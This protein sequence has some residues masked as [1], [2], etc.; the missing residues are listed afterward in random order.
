MDYRLNISKKGVNA[1]GVKANGKDAGAMLWTPY[2]MDLSEY[3]KPGDNEVELTIVNNL[4]NLM[5]PHH[6][7]Q[8]E[9]IMPGPVSFRKLPSLWTGMEEMPWNDDYCFMEFSIE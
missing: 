1:I 3:L 2:T 5:G 8:G 4:R 9:N 6:D 7:P